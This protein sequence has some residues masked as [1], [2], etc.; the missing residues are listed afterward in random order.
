MRYTGRC[1]R[2][3]RRGQLVPV[4][5]DRLYLLEYLRTN[6]KQRPI[7]TRGAARDCRARKFYL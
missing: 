1:I 7:I 2:R 6:R 5:Y 3:G 4:L